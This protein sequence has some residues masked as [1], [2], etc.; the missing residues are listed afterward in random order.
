M[1]RSVAAEHPGDTGSAAVSG[2]QLPEPEVFTSFLLR[3]DLHGKRQRTLA[4]GARRPCCKPTQR[5]TPLDATRMRRSPAH[6]YSFLF[7]QIKLVPHT[8]W[9]VPTAHSQRHTTKP[10]TQGHFFFFLTHRTAVCD[11]ERGFSLGWF[12]VRLGT[13][14]LASSQWRF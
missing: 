2:A 13:K 7:R 6:I 4:Q 8:A 3:T 5:K 14:G 11:Y 9:H 1:H 10:R 12:H